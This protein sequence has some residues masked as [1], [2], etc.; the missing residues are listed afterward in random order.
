MQPTTHSNLFTAD[1]PVLGTS[2]PSGPSRWATLTSQDLLSLRVL[3]PNWLIEERLPS[4]GTSLLVGHP[5]AKP[6]GI[7]RQIALA[8]ARGEPWLDFST[9]G[10]RVLYVHPAAE[11]ERLKSDFAESGLRPDDNIHFL[12]AR[13]R[14]AL[15]ARICEHAEG[16]RPGLIVLEGFVALVRSDRPTE[17][18]PCLP[19]LAEL[20]RLA[21]H[22]RSHI[23]MVQETPADLGRA[24]NPLLEQDE[25]IDTVLVLHRLHS[26]RL[27][28]SIQRYGEDIA[29]ELPGDGTSGPSVPELP[30]PAVHSELAD[31]IVAYLKLRAAMVSEEEVCNQLDEGDPREIVN[32]LRALHGAGH[33][34]RTGKGT[35]RS[36]FRYTGF[37]VVSSPN[38]WLRRVRT[39]ASPIPRR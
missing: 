26:R 23:M 12:G 37:E 10:E 25:H 20:R 33:L 29:I 16:L 21:V 11:L 2:A 8:T 35:L 24:L 15:M 9:R 7:G 18:W 19:A 28:T 32:T 30:D 34:V 38:S 27:L 39:W 1:T 3:D 4:V 14:G 13:P 6:S 17:V 36:P 31:Q 22:T 5:D